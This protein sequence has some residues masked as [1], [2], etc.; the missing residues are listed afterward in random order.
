MDRATFTHGHAD[1]IGSP[2]PLTLS[3]PLGVAKLKYERIKSCI[4]SSIMFSCWRTQS[5]PLPIE[6]AAACRQG[7]GRF[8]FGSENSLELRGIACGSFCSRFY[9]RHGS[10][11]P[12]TS[13]TKPRASDELALCECASDAP[14][15]NSPL[16]KPPGEGT[17]PTIHANVRRNPV[18]RVPSRGNQDV[19]EQAAERQR[20]RR[21][22]TSR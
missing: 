20:K 16:K 6:M 1:G 22:A 7:F 13:C 5:I 18:G 11:D 19:F 4:V 8:S 21:D 2:I 9:V 15:A 17:G 3:F 10:W 14:R 12:A